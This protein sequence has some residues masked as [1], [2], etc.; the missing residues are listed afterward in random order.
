MT[1]CLAAVSAQPN[2]MDRASLK[3]NHT[4]SMTRSRTL[5]KHRAELG[6]AWKLIRNQAGTK[7]DRQG[8]GGA[9]MHLTAAGL[10]S[11]ICVPTQL[12]V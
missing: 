11:D 6:L 1:G 2:A 12:L 4:A 9:F 3:C 7:K 10:L 5:L 8:L